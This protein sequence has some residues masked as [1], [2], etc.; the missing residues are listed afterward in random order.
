LETNPDVGLNERGRGYLKQLRAAIER[1]TGF[2]E[3]QLRLARVTYT[4]P[5]LEEHVDMTRLVHEVVGDGTLG[6]RAAG[7]SIEVGDMPTIRADSAQF[8]QLFRNLLENAVKYR[9][10]DAP[11]QVRIDGAVVDRDGA[12]ACEIRVSDNGQG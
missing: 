7:A 9:R 8:R 10:P 6:L 12:R 3:A 5:T 4:Q 1:M 2:L 11:L